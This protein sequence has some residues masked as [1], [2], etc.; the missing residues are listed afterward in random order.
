MDKKTAKIN[1]RFNFI[2]VLIVAVILVIVAFAAYLF[3]GNKLVSLFNSGDNTAYLRYTITM[4]SVEDKYVDYIN[5]DSELMHGSKSIGIIESVKVSEVE[6]IELNERT[7]ELVTVGYPDHK[8]VEISVVVK[9]A[10]DGG[11]FTADNVK[12][13]VGEYV[14]FKT[15]GFKS[16]GYITSF[17][18]LPD[19]EEPEILAR[20]AAKSAD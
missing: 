2:D 3:L 15:L 10:E 7:G 9:A 5:E 4:N 19:G 1:N 11:I 12:I 17:E 16:Y 14:E 13:A 20:A 8:K 6:R 18:R